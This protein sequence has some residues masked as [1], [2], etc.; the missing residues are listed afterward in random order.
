MAIAED[1]QASSAMVVTWQVGDML[2]SLIMPAPVH[3]EAHEAPCQG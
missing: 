3:G 2:V 1:E